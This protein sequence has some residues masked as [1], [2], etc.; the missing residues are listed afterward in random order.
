MFD[1]Y[2][3]FMPQWSFISFYLYFQPALTLSHDSN[4]LIALTNEQQ[5]GED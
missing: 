3:Q 4:L 1:S 5:I 2:L